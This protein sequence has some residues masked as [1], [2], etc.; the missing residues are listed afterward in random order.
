MGGIVKAAVEGKNHSYLKSDLVVREISGS[1]IYMSRFR[2]N[3]FAGMTL[4]EILES[5]E[6]MGCHVLTLPTVVPGGSKDYIRNWPDAAT[7]LL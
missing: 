4:D 1:L 6:Q 7:S 3:Y 2:M 5:V